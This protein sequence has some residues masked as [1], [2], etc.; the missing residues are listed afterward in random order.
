MTVWRLPL[1]CFCRWMWQ[2]AP[3]YPVGS[4]WQLFPPFSSKLFYP[5]FILF[6][7]FGHIFY[8]F[9][10]VLEAGKRLLSFCVPNT[11][12]WPTDPDP[13]R[14]LLFSSMT[15]K[16]QSKIIFILNFLKVHFTIHPM[17]HF[18]NHVSKALNEKEHTI[19]IFCD[20]RKAFDSCNHQILLWRGS[21]IIFR[22][23]LNLYASMV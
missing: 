7:Y 20:L 5:L 13:V 18:A 15:F 3:A 21:L 10:L 4:W 2:K 17:T 11:Y 23:A 9:I 1:R 16:E 22:S 14:I 12:L 6:S 19:A 8:S